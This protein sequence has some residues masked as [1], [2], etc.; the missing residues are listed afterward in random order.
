MSSDI[1]LTSALRS[2]LL[3]LQ[4]TQSLIDQTQLR[5]ATGRKVNSA[6]DNPQ[7]FFAGQALNNRADDLNR[8]LD[9]ISQSIRTIEEADN[10]I[11][12]LTDLVEQADSIATSA[13]DIIA[14]VTGSA[15]LVG[16]VDLSG[17]TDLTSFA[18]IATDSAFEI[19]TTD[20]DGNQIREEFV[21]ATGDTAYSLTARITDAFADNEN[22]EI[23]ATVT[24]EGFISIRSANG[25]SFRIE[26]DFVTAPQLSGTQGVSNA[27][28]ADLGL[29]DYFEI[30]TAENAGAAAAD[31]R[32]AATIIAGNT[33]SSISLFENS[34][35]GD[36]VE[37]GDSI[38]GLNAQ[39]ASGTTVFS[40]FA[41][42]DTI[43]FDVVAD[44][45]TQTVTFTAGLA[46]DG[47]TFQD[48]VDSINGDA[49]VSPLIEANFDSNT[50]QL[51]FT[52]LSD[53]VDSFGITTATAAAGTFD[54]GLGD[55]SGNLDPV[56]IQAGEAEERVYSFNSSTEELDDLAGDYNSIREQIDALVQDASYR[57]INLLNGDNLTTFFNEDRSNSLVT[58][59]G[60]FTADGLGL[61][62]ANFRSV[63][64]IDNNLTAVREALNGVRS[65][66]ASIANDL[67][68]IQTRQDFTQKTINTLNAGADDLT[69]ADQNEEGANLLALQTRQQLGVT[70][71][72]LASQS[73]QA[74]LRLF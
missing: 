26:D 9:G 59:G 39:D 55:P 17:V 53:S 46:N 41:A 4:N 28:F 63:S 15:R 70:S 47:E 20:A 33:L 2:N 11:T 6:L 31:T 40:G 45:A 58:E 74:V 30:E 50:G 37:A 8:L 19:V 51:S 7:N 21:I 54:I 36:V 32:A 60:N 3:S 67:A 69:V 38:I 10:G 64:G 16:E 56:T 12:A 27:G 23:T 71:L 68:V 18:N 5:L 49:N 34:G 65:F 72:S 43:T 42:G 24:D 29:G 61:N 73:Q 13:R 62:E 44:G 35:A 66:G 14:G 1:V 48:I 22:G 57:G 52:S 25:Q